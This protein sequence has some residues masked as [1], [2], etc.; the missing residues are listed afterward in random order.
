MDIL[1][2]F[3]NRVFYRQSSANVATPI[4]ILAYSLCMFSSIYE[5]HT[6][7]D[8]FVVSVFRKPFIQN[9]IRS[10]FHV[11]SNIALYLIIRYA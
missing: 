2:S 9:I 1:L 4:E 3:I 7:L 11:L 8:N 5:T 10:T 6:L